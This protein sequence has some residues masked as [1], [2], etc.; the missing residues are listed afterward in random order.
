[1]KFL[2]CHGFPVIR[3]WCVLSAKNRNFIRELHFIH[4]AFSKFEV[5]EEDSAYFVLP[6]YIIIRCSFPEDFIE[7]A[8]LCSTAC[9]K[10]SDLAKKLHFLMKKVP[11]VFGGYVVKQ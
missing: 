2:F 6:L 5:P 1:M 4:L 11:E 7:C 10:I 9:L 3:V 8:F